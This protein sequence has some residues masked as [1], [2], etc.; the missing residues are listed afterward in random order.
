[1]NTCMWTHPVTARQISTLTD[2][3]GVEGAN[4][5]SGWYEV[6]MP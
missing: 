2:A 1:L 3:W 6:L 5:S 4:A